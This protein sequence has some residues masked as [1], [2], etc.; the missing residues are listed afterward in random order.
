MGRVT[1]GPT[2]SYLLKKSS[3][4]WEPRAGWCCTC[5]LES[6]AVAK[7]RST[8]AWAHPWGLPCPSTVVQ[9]HTTAPAHLAHNHLFV[10]L[11]SLPCPIL[12]V[13]MAQTINT[14][15]VGFLHDSN[16]VSQYESAHYFHKM[17]WKMIPLPINAYCFCLGLIPKFEER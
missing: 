11:A 5:C 3:H 13:Q 2:K 16:K 15:C 8:K 1:A 6:L 17:L 14:G 12:P 7:G 10:I 9:T 4:Q